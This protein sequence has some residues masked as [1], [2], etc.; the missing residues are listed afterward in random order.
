MVR[1]SLKSWPR[2]V[3]KG[4]ADSSAIVKLYSDEPGD[5]LVRSMD[6]L[7]IS[8]LAWVEVPAALWRKQRMGELSIEEVNVLT[9]Q[10]ERDYRGSSNIEPRFVTVSVAESI[11]VHATRLVGTY[12]LRVYHAVQLSTAARAREITDPG[13]QFVA[14]DRELRLAAAREGFAVIPDSM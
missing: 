11:L 5:K 6:V 1:R 13:L 7:I 2:N 4:F 8:A 3:N 10:F 12:G 14:F 9:A